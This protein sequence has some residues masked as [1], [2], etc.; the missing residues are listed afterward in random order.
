MRRMTAAF[1]GIVALLA[2]LWAFRRFL[3]SGQGGWLA[4]SMLLYV[5]NALTYEIALLFFG[6]YAIVAYGEKLNWRAAAR[7]TTSSSS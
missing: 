4:L 1:T 2:S 6:S 3:R 5:A 7:W